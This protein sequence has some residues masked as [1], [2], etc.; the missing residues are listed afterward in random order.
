MSMETFDLS[1]FEPD[2]WAAAA[3]QD[4]KA[5]EA[6]ARREAIPDTPTELALFIGGPADAEWR[7]VGEGVE[8]LLIPGNWVKDVTSRQP[9]HFIYR[10]DQHAAS[11]VFDY[12]GP[13]PKYND[14]GT[15]R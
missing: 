9:G 8:E 7:I 6:E 11:P 14:D 15:P 4:R 10:R 1:R 12:I 5:Q 2:P 3:E 13:T